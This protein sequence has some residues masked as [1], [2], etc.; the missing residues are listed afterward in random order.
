MAKVCFQPK[1]MAKLCFECTEVVV[2][3]RFCCW[4]FSVVAGHR[5]WW[6]WQWSMGKDNDRKY[7][8]HKIGPKLRSN[9][10]TYSWNANNIH[11]VA[12]HK[13][14]RNINISSEWCKRM[15]NERLSQSIRRAQCDVAYTQFWLVPWSIEM[16]T[17]L[18][19]GVCWIV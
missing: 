10:V 11:M 9:D 7:K 13:C 4:Y 2:W 18:L 6:W 15:R 16:V 1:T 12:A 5:W 3:C 17:M 8:S 19:N 14:H